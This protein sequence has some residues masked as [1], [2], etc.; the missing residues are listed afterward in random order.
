[1]YTRRFIILLSLFVCSFFSCRQINVY[2]F[3]TNIPKQQ[4]N[5]N[6]SAKGSFKIADTSATYNLYLVLRHLDAYK[7]ENIW[8]N[9]GL[10]GSGDSL[11]MQ[12]LNLTLAKDANGWEGS[13]MNDIWEVRKLLN[14]QPRKFI[15]AGVYQFSINQIMRDN[16]LPGILS[17]GLRVEK[18]S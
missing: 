6:F 15:K 13:G 10:S 1:M 3:N 16:P 12:K 8:L 5:H 2:E 7:Y 14:G 4:W 11:Y 18:A 9:V 17:A